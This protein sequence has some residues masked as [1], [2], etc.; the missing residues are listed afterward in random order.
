M[1]NGQPDAATGLQRVHASATD[2]DRQRVRELASVF[3]HAA[4]ANEAQGN[5]IALG[6]WPQEAREIA[7]ALRAVSK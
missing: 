4:Q 1:S 5:R 3:E 2:D 7:E 6:W